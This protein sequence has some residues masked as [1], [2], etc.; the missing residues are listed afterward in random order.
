MG[1]IISAFIY[2]PVS[3]WTVAHFE[4]TVLWIVTLA[5][6]GAGKV[7]IPTASGTVVFRRYRERCSATARN[8][9]HAHHTRLR[10]LFGFS[11][12]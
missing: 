3:F 6:A 1:E 8:Q 5:A 9:I 7:T 4:N 2:S 12:H 11:R 10:F